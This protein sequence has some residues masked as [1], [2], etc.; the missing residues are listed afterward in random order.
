M[1]NGCL[2]AFYLGSPQCQLPSNGVDS[3]LYELILLNK[4]ESH[5]LIRAM[6]ATVHRTLQGVYKW[7]RH[8]Q[9]DWQNRIYVC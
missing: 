3:S 5:Q 2:S 9:L 6:V 8:P 7:L 4:C 1:Y